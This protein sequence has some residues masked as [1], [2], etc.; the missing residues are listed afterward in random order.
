MI[1]DRR[2][3]EGSRRGAVSREAAPGARAGGGGGHVEALHSTP[4][5]CLTAV[6]LCHHRRHVRG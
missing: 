1:G 2:R 5:A 4:P 6:A 3:K